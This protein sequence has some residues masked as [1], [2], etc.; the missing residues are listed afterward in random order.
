M[1]FGDAAAPIA[2][3]VTVD[4]SERYLTR[5]ARNGLSM[6]PYVNAANPMMIG[7]PNAD[8]VIKASSAESPVIRRTPFF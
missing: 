7:K 3:T 1:I 8:V 4:A 2:R 6:T 5:N